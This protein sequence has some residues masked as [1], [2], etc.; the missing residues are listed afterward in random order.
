MDMAEYPDDKTGARSVATP[1]ETSL[2]D[3]WRQSRLALATPPVRRQLSWVSVGIVAVIIATSIGQVLLNSWNQPFYDAL[4]RRDMAAFLHQL[5]VFA[6]IAGTLLVLNI[7]QTRFNQ[8]CRLK[9]RQALTLDLI[10]QW[11]RPERAFRLPMPAS[12]GQSRPAHAAGRRAPLGPSGFVFQVNGWSLAIPGYMV[13]AAFLYAGTASWLSWLVGR[14][15]IS[16][17]SDRYTREAELRS[18]MVRV[19]ENVD[20][21]YGLGDTFVQSRARSQCLIFGHRACKHRR[22]VQWTP[23]Q[24]PRR[25]A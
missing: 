6:V 15:L 18:S 14:P 16:L 22:R 7:G 10:D 3:N 4:A 19:N 2:H 12:S 5:L 23:R 1:V 25:F 21:H 11:M 8:M 24:S 13:W 9:L 20:R 17:N